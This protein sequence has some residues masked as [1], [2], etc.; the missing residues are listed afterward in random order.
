[1]EFYYLLAWTDYLT[2]LS[3]FPHP[4]KWVSLNCR[5]I[6]FLLLEMASTEGVAMEGE[7]LLSSLN[8]R[9]KL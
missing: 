4:Y 9:G 3:L 8:R 6:I 2:S 5:L 7:V 1:M